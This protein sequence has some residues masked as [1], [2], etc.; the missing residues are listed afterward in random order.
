MRKLFVLAGL[1]GVAAVVAKKL[2]E[3]KAQP[4]WHTPD[5]DPESEPPLSV[6]PDVADDAAGAGP[7][8]EL[9]DA[10]EGPHGA[11]TPDAPLE[12]ND[13]P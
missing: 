3:Q 2:K 8:E 6:V 5:T 7:D 1:A 9:A 4:V 10:A 11:T 12:E 13:V